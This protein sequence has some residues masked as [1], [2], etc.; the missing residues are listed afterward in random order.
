MLIRFGC[1]FMLVSS[2]ARLGLNLGFYD[3]VDV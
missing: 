3:F 1:L 2:F